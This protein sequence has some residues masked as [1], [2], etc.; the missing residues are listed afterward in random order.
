M[1]MVENEDVFVAAQGPV[2]AITSWGAD[3]LRT[4]LLTL[5][6]GTVL[7]LEPVTLHASDHGDIQAG[8]VSGGD[9]LSNRG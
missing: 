7:N 9:L 4:V 8:R 3:L 5:R 6:R 2:A 1:V